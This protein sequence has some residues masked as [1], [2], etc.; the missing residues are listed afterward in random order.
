MRHKR[1][2]EF[3]KAMVGKKFNRWTVLRHES[4]E[5][6]YWCRCDCGTEKAVRTDA[7]KKGSSKSCGCLEKDIGRPSS[8]KADNYSAKRE[9]YKNYKQAANR[10]NYS[11]DLSLE[12]F[13]ELTQRPCWYC[14]TEKSMA[15]SLKAHKDYRFNGVDRIDNREG[16]TEK[17]S[18][19][20][21]NIC[22][23]SKACLSLKE[24]KEWIDRVHNHKNNVG[25]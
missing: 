24:W 13:T 18:V 1:H 15:S 6:G 22:N 2:E 23:N 21:C 17:N 5:K 7:L 25:F 4:R 14:G 19:P 20:C 10:R 3:V 9:V 12:E 16:Y 8:R 11:F